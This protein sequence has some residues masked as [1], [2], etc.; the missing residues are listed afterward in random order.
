MQVT[1]ISGVTVAASTNVD[2]QEWDR[3]VDTQ[4]EATGYHLWRWRQVMERGLG[5][6]C[7][8]FAARQDG[9]IVGILP[10]AE[11]R[12][13]FVGSALSSLPYLNYG[14][15]LAASP[16]AAAALVEHVSGI[17]SEERL[18]Y[19]VLR[20][21]RRLFSDLP[22]RSHKQTMMLAL[23]ETA[24]AMWTALD[25]K[26]RNQIR[27]AE[28]S[29]LSVVAGGAELVDDFYGVF[30]RNMRDLGTP[31]YGR[32]LF[33][34][35]VRACPEGVRIHVVRLNG[36][37]VAAAVSYRYREIVEVPSAS[38]LREHRGLCPNHMLYWHIIQMSITE[39][40][41]TLDFGRSTPGDGTYQFKEQWGAVPEQLEWEYVLG[42]GQQLPTSDRHDS[43][44][45]VAIA[46]WKR[47]PVGVTTVLGPR[48]ARVVP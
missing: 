24:E 20:H 46:A 32:E 41:R 19:L 3:F 42:R 11:V 38:A 16:A 31:V 29:G 45:N 2:A 4:A 8:Y 33:A 39:G 12:R 7:R 36:L 47:L 13:P 21:R 34:E 6:R 40:A 10:T 18:S 35:M 14:G 23:S 26:V 17:V 43:K 44:F 25:R 28:K 15:I 5:H 9:R 22:V 27:K 1:S 30:A 37:T 48:L